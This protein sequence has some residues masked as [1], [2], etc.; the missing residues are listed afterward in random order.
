M[1]IDP[2]TAIAAAGAAGSLFGG[3][4]QA[5]AAVPEDLI[6]PRA[7]T[8]ALLRY[9]LGYGSPSG[10]GGAGSQQYGKLS[11]AVAKN[12][13]RQ[14]SGL[15][16][17]SGDPTGRLEGFFG[18][19][20]V[21]TSDLQRQSLGGIQQY[22]AAPP[23]EQKA[24]GA[25]DKI[26]TQNPGQGMLDALQ[27]RFQQNLSAAN[28]QGPRFSSGNEL[29]RARAVDDYNLL[30]QQAMQQGVQQQL[31]AAQLSSL[32]GNSIFDRLSSAY[33]I[34]QQEANQGD[35]ATQRRLGILMNLLGVQQSS[36]LGLPVTQGQNFWTGLGQGATNFASILK[37]LQGLNVGM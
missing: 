24:L 34:G 36:T 18:K 3:S 16:D 26:L 4:G 17:L 29:L 31:Q 37:S 20:G 14:G 21:P 22:L 12:A 5:Q 25:L 11:P 2:G 32:L 27:P 35:I 23:P 30:S 6:G 8:L 33:G 15:P 13:A 28:Q 19:L 1:P 9:L 7:D 10:G